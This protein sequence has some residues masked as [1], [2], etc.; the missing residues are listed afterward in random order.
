M[1]HVALRKELGPSAAGTSKVFSKAVGARLVTHYSHGGLLLNND[2]LHSTYKDGLHKAAILMEDRWDL[3]RVP[4]AL[5][6]FVASRFKYMQGT[7]YDAVSLFAFL[8]PWRVRDSKR[9]YCFEW[10]WY[11]LTGTIPNFRVTP[12]MLLT[13]TLQLHGHV[14]AHPALTLDEE[15]P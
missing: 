11:G 5:E 9:M 3:F 7:K 14:I 12:E 8:L 15:L 2:L 6:P 10:M 13:L 1:L 4:E